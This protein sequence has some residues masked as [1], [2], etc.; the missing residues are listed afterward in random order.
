MS[1]M[2]PCPYDSHPV[3]YEQITSPLVR[4]VAL[5][6]EGAAGPSGIDA[7]GRQ[8]LRLCSSAVQY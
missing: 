2:T 7:Q 3:I 8:W 6:T 1:P 5:K 4:S